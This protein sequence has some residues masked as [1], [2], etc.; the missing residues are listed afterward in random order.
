MNRLFYDY[1]HRTLELR[2][3][4]YVRVGSS[5]LLNHGLVRSTRFAR[6]GY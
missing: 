6:L 2:L 3:A 4:R 1:L 5:D